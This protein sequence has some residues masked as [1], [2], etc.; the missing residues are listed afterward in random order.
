[1]ASVSEGS[2]SRYQYPAETVVMAYDETPSRFGERFEPERRPVEQDPFLDTAGSA[3]TPPH[4]LAPPSRGVFVHED[5]GSI[6]SF[7]MSG[8]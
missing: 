3:A 5:G 8:R 4:S 6:R 1:M 2:E 7:G